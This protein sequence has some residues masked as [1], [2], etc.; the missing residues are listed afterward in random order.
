MVKDKNKL[1][2]P[3]DD[4]QSTLDSEWSEKKMFLI[5][6]NSRLSTWELVISG[7]ATFHIDS[8]KLD[9]GRVNLSDHKVVRDCRVF[10]SFWVLFPA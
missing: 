9:R 7:P 2:M 3:A 1:I 5:W 6:I 4:M 8:S 10:S